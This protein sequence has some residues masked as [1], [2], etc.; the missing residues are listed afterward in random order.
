MSEDSARPTNILLSAYACEPG[1]GSEQAVGWG[2]VLG[3]AATGKTLTV[4]TRESNRQRIEAWLSGNRLP[5]VHFIHFDLPPFFRSLKKKPG[6]G[7]LYYLAW[8][9]GAYRVARGLVSRERFDLV[10]H[11]TFVTARLTSFMGL[12]GIPFVFGPVAGGEYAPYK[13]WRAFPLRDRVFEWLRYLSIA[14]VRYSPLM[15]LCFER[16]ALIVCTSQDTLECIPRR[17]HGKCRELLAITYDEPLPA[18]RQRCVEAGKP[19]RV[20][21]AGR[22]IEFKGF[23]FAVAALH[24]LQRQGIPFELTVIAAGPRLAAWQQ[25]VAAREMQQAVTFLKGLDRSVFLEVLA[26]F[27]VMLFPSLHDSGG[28]VVLEAMAA[29][30]PVVCLG[31]GGPRQIVD[32]TCGVVVDVGSEE[33]IVRDLAFALTVLAQDDALRCRLGLAAADRVATHFR[34]ASRVA[35]MEEM[36]REVLRDAA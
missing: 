23:R 3:L 25:D 30:V 13:A 18:A 17:Y 34:L 24:E 2:W 33:E 27:D 15:R 19:M 1:L 20:V 35:S 28:M 11:V 5:N 7:Y 36:Y 10:H 22:A 29:G 14:W 8:Q 26:G 4:I 6:F 16:A 31:V 32:A 9:F 21:F 12:L